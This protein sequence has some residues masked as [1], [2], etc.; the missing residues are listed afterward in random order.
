[1]PISGRIASVKG[2]AV[3]RSRLMRDPGYGLSLALGH[4]RKNSGGAHRVRFTP[5]ERTSS[6]HAALG[7]GLGSTEPPQSHRSP[8][9]IVRIVSGAPTLK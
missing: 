9:A 1:M 8:K 4:A 2:A 6:G 3:S 7:I 5:K